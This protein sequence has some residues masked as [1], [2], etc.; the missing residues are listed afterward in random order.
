MYITSYALST[1]TKFE[2]GKFLG[3]FC[4][5][6]K[7]IFVLNL[8]SAN[9]L[10]DVWSNVRGIL[11]HVNIV[12]GNN[13]EFAAVAELENW[14]SDDLVFSAGKLAGMLNKGSQPSF[15]VITRGKDP[16]FV[17]SSDFTFSTHPVPQIPPEEI[18][19]TNG[20]GDGFVGAFL[21]CLQR[22]KPN[23]NTFSLEDCVSAGNF[24][25]GLVLRH[26]GFGL[27][28]QTQAHAD[29]LKTLWKI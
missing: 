27:P 23:S 6:H 12:I 8:S 28:K 21:C 14:D 13:G 17:V 25:A 29:Q 1:Q 9:L 11:S 26:S 19:D 3:D 2:V 7:K 16:T 4:A 24:C 18:V 15:V 22:K 20:A 10:R 5:E